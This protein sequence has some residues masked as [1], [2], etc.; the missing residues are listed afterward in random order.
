M[1]TC[2]TGTRTV[3]RIGYDDP[4][5]YRYYDLSFYLSIDSQ[6]T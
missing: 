3:R 1:N 4:Y 6:H 5:E 2:S